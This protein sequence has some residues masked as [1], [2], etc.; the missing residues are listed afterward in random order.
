MNEEDNVDHVVSDVNEPAVENSQIERTETVTPAIAEGHESDD[1]GIE[2]QENA[3]LD[4]S[5]SVVLQDEMDENVL[6]SEIAR[7]SGVG[8][9]NQRM[10]ST[11]EGPLEVTLLYKSSQLQLNNFHWDVHL[12]LME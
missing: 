12:V 1:E 11:V 2:V 4:E 8:M 5:Q 7:T 6:S 9:L 10:E 3:V